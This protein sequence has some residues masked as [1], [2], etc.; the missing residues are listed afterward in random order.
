MMCKGVHVETFH[1]RQEPCGL[2]AVALHAN[3]DV[4]DDGSS[5][6]YPLY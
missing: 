5:M 1:L 4:D 2:Q 3:W 6:L